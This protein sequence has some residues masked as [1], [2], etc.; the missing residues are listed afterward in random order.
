MPRGYNQYDEASLQGRL[1]NPSRLLP[2]SLIHGWWDAADASTFTLTNTGAVGV[3]GGAVEEWRDKTGNARHLQQTD[4]N[5]RPQYRE[6]IRNIGGQ[7]PTVRFAA[8]TN[9]M[10]FVIANSLA[11]RTATYFHAIG[12]RKSSAATAADT[13]TMQPIIGTNAGYFL[14]GLSSVLLSGDTSSF[15]VVDTSA[16]NTRLGTT[17][18]AYT[19]VAEQPEIVWCHT[20]NLTTYGQNFG[21]RL[22]GRNLTMNLANQTPN[23]SLAPASVTPALTSMTVSTGTITT[24]F[25][26]YSEIIVSISSQFR[27]HLELVEGYLS[28]KWGVPLN[29]NH[30]FANRPPLIG[31]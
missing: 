23:S 8:N 18:A 28:W 24:G 14:G 3:A 20:N 15:I 31:D 4:P 29:A 21:V 17:A 30:P 16:G 11:F 7:L 9:G 10:Y 1:W 2:S 19:R 22:N 5:L 27:S 6:K 13:N 26:D 12:V 25:C